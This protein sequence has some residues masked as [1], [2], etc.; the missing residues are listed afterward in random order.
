[1]VDKEKLRKSIANELIKKEGRIDQVDINM[2]VREEV[3]RNKYVR[4]FRET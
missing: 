4:Q 2:L 3:K 1:M